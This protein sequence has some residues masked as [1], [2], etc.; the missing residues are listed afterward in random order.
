MIFVMAS[1]RGSSRFSNRARRQATTAG[2]SSDLML[3]DV[4]MEI[5]CNKSKLKEMKEERQLGLA[6]AQARI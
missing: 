3:D 4:V 6:R 5:K 2:R 1:N